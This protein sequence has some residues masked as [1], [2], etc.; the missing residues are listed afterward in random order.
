[1]FLVRAVVCVSPII[2]A[3]HIRSSAGASM[4]HSKPASDGRRCARSDAWLR[5]AVDA[6][7]G[8]RKDNFKSLNSKTFNFGSDC[9]G[10]DAAFTAAKIWCE[11]GGVCARNLMASEA[12]GATGP[13]LFQLLNHAPERL[14]I[15]VLARAHSGFDL[16]SNCVQKTPADL[17]LYAFGSMC[18]DFSSFNTMNPKKLLGQLNF[19]F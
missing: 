12:P 5:C 8:M 18:T 13:I 2:A 10:A 7:C 3:W 16:I 1:M 4:S 11:A 19:S 17:D 6:M 15:D 9:T 14:F